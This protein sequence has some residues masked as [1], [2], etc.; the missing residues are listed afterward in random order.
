MDKIKWLML[1]YKIP[2]SPSKLRIYIWRKFKLLNA[3][4]LQDSVV[5]LPYTKR[6]LENMR[7]LAQEIKDIGGV[8]FLWEAVSLGPT[9]DATVRKMFINFSES[10]YNDLLD[11]ID[12]IDR[13]NIDIKELT[14]ITKDFK[15]TKASD[16][17]NVNLSKVVEAKLEK[18][19][20]EIR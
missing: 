1:V 13:E 2:S 14:K 16:Y 9:E 5:I 8:S 17:Y 10:M 6:T 15:T 12:K 19:L 11:R 20:E 7:W 4:Y 18:I 3:Q